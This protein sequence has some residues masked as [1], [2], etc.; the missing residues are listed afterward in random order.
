MKNHRL[1]IPAVLVFGLCS[2]CNLAI[3]AGSTVFTAE[4]PAAS[5]SDGP[6][7]LGMK[8]TSTQAGEITKIRFYR[9]FGEA[10]DG[11]EFWVHVGNIWDED[12]NLL[13]TVPFAGATG[14]DGEGW[15]SISLSRP[16][17]IE[18]DKTY[19]VSVNAVSDYVATPQGLASPVT[20][21]PLSSIAD[22]DNGVFSLKPGRF[23]NKSYNNNNYFVD[24]EVVPNDAPPAR[25]AT[26]LTSQTPEGSYTD[27]PYELG[28]RW[29]STQPGRITKIRFYRAFGEPEDGG[30]SFVHVGRIWD[31][32]GRLLAVV[33]FTGFGGATGRTGEGWETVPL[34]RPLAI[35]ADKTYVV[36]VNVL[37]DYVATPGGLASAMSNGPLSSVADGKNGVFSFKPGTFPTR[38]YNNTNY[39]VDVEVEVGPLPFSGTTTLFTTETPKEWYSD[40]PYELGMKWKSSQAG[41]ITKMRF[42]RALNEAEDGGEFYVHLGRIWDEH[43]NLLTTVPFAGAAGRTGEGWETVSLFRPLPI[44][45]DR[46]YVVSV[47]VVSDYVGTMQELASPVING[48]LS[49]IA[50]GNNGVYSTT[51]GAF[52]TE[53]W[54]NS[55]YYVDV[56]V[57]Y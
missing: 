49:S 45:A 38:S 18:A 47:N 16:L 42:Y 1:T 13:L 3:G 33:P 39:F 30:P 36:S 5:F 26:V 41:V 50:D 23:P 35:E 34:I 28:M 9:A 51:P 14:R 57:S 21:G 24:V 25:S 31:E 2:F 10:E 17:A 40:G 11:G 12:G 48:P 22:G 37:R 44:E 53:S 56:E 43:G 6:Y 8:W 52:P 29:T 55:N 19:V 27:G 20:N 46:T 54:F 7:E 15:E 4:T 32:N